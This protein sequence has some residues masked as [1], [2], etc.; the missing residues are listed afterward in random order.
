M[1]SQRF[2]LRV[3]K[4]KFYP[5]CLQQSSRKFRQVSLFLLINHQHL[6]LLSFWTN[7]SFQRDDFSFH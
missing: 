5:E 3:G 1:F 2:E 7:S 4:L 6:M